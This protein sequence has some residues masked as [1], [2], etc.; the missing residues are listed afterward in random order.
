MRRLSAGLCLISL[1]LAP[2]LTE[3][4][5]RS[6]EEIQWFDDAAGYT[7]AVSL[8]EGSGALVLVYFYT[9]WCPYCRQL[10]NGLLGDPEVQSQVGKMLAVR[11][12]A[13]AGP[14][15]RSLAGS[16][17]VRGYPAL[18]LYT[19]AQG[20]S[21]EPLRRTVRADSGS[22]RMKTPQEFVDSLRGAVR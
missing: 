12:N 9:D 5:T 8:A 20:G 19:A 15:E 4:E 13:E 6:W 17:R 22:V 1:L 21:F 18:Y 7:Q 3:A 16:Y 10:N 14:D 2:A 11:V